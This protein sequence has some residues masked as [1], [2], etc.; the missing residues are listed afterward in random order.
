MRLAAAIQDRRGLASI[1]HNSELRPTHG[2]GHRDRAQDKELT[3]RQVWRRETI[4]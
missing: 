2:C 3:M 1:R 4:H